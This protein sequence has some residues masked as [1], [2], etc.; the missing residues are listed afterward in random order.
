MRRKGPLAAQ[1]MCL[2]DDRVNSARFSLHQPRAQSGQFSFADRPCLVQ[3][4]EQPIRVGAKVVSYGPTSLFRMLRSPS[5]DKVS[6]S[7]D[8]RGAN[9]GGSRRRLS[10]LPERGKSATIHAGWGFIWGIPD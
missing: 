4:K 1:I 9:G 8:V 2:G 3:L 10:V 7:A 6:P 5:H